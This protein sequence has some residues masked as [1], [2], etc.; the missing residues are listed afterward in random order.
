MVV[1]VTYEGN[2]PFA[3][4]TARQ[5]ASIEFASHCAPAAIHDGVWRNIYIQT[6]FYGP[7]P[8][9]NPTIRDAITIGLWQ[10]GLNSLALFVMNA[11]SLSPLTGTSTLRVAL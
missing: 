10:S 11:D 4:L 9:S 7:G 5:A 8:W 1:S 3:N 2:L 6:Q